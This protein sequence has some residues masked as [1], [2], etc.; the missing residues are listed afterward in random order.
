MNFSLKEGEIVVSLEGNLKDKDSVIKTT[1][2][3]QGH[4]WVEG[5]NPAYSVDSRSYGPIP[6]QLIV[7]RVWRT[8][9]KDFYF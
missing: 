6:E 9:N 2:V 5:D 8:V 7:G 3:P 4:V 1:F